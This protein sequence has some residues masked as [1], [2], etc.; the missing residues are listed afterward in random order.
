[1]LLLGGRFLTASKDGTVILWSLEGTVIRVVRGDDRV[2][3]GEDHG[4]IRL[5]MGLGLGLFVQALRLSQLASGMQVFL[6]RPIPIR[7]PR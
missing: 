1:M 7:M 6:R 3:V 4:V 2:R 5:G